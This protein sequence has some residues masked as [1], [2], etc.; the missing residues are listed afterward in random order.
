MQTTVLRVSIHCEGCKKKVRKVLLAIE[1]TEYVVVSFVRF[2]S[3][4]HASFYFG[5]L[6]IDRVECVD[7]Y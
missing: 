1:G 3:V 6:S 7:N 4:F 2:V 5:G